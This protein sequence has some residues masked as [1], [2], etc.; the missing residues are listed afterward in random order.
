[1]K[2]GIFHILASL[3]I[4]S[5]VSGCI[6]NDL[7][8]PRIQQNILALEADG[9]TKAAVIDS[10]VMEA[11]VYLDE[12]TDIE[13]VRF[14][15]F[16]ITPGAKCDP[17]LSDGTYDLSKP[18]VVTVSKYQDYYWTVSAVQNIDRYFDVEGQIGE[19]VIDPVGHRVI[20]SLAEGTDL[21]NLVLKRVKL[22]PEGITTMTPDILPGPLDLSYPLRVEVTAH[23]RTTIWTI[24]A[25]YTELIVSTSAVDAWSEVIWA[26]GDGP[27]DVQNSFQY[28]EASSDEWIDVDI[29][30]VTQTQGSFTCCIRHLKPLTEY[31][32]RAVSDEDHGNE[33]KVTTQATAD[34][35]DGDFEDWWL[36]GK[37]WFPY[38]QGGVQ[39]WDTGNTGTAT[40][41]QNNVQPTDYTPSGKGKAA[42]LDT[43]FVGLMGIGKLAAGSIYTGKFAKV[44]GMNGILD[45]GRPWNLRPTMLK[46]YFQYQTAEINYASAELEYLKGRPD[47]CHIYVA[48]TDWT[49]PYQIRTN[50]KNRQLFDKNADYIIAY[51]E[52]I[53][54]GTM[55]KYKEFEIRLNYKSTSRIPSYMQITCATSKY[56][57]YFTGGTGATLYVDQLW[58]EWDLP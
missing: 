34:I 27:S 58:Y 52:L 50:P 19:S 45:F 35:P 15:K 49:A 25:Q 22:G 5:V 33:V 17:D 47:S 16:E 40:L 12:T 53:F 37:I 11:I 30:D 39:Y 55:D 28:R 32:V 26:Y 24:Y 9:Q 54:G 7:P 42:M 38:A 48:L 18:M 46:G 10:M 31:A 36:D 2:K 41:G 21:K 4:F 43:R 56:G 13:H 23:G 20:V 14:S 57:D 1:M 6:K 3:M 44:D 29:K 51:G 8:F